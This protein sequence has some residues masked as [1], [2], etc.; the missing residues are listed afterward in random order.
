LDGHK[1]LVGILPDF[2][3]QYLAP[4]ERYGVLILLALIM[5]G[6]LGR[7][8]LGSMYD[9]VYSSLS[10]LIVGGRGLPL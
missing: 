2:W 1:I 9:P 7:G 6:G 5:F 4:L 8:I 10:S 3:Y